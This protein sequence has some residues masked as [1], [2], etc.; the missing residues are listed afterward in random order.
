MSTSIKYFGPR[1]TLNTM[2]FYNCS[3]PVALL[4]HEQIVDDCDDNEE[5]PKHSKS[6]P[7]TY[8]AD[9]PPADYDFFLDDAPE[10][11]EMNGFSPGYDYDEDDMPE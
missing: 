1:E 8:E 7:T 5:V 10:A 2:E 6:G 3:F 4:I 11:L 9:M